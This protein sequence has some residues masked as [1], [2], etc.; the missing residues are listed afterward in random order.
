MVPVRHLKLFGGLSIEDDAG[1][2][3]GRAAQR[4]RLAVLALLATARSGSVSRDRLITYVWPEASAENGRHFLSDSVYRINQ[5]LGGDIILAAGDELRLDGT[6]LPSDVADFEAALLAGDHERAVSVYTGPFLD[7]F[8]LPDS[9]EFE[10]WTEAERDRLQ[11]ACLG[12]LETVA[13]DA[14]RR[15]HLQVAVAYWR[16]VAAFDPY[17]SRIAVQLMEALDAAGDRAAAIQ[18]ARI[19]ET[20]LREE[21]EIEPDPDV[22]ALADAL[23]SGRPISSAQAVGSPHRAVPSGGAGRSR[24]DAA[25][26]ATP[27]S[28][29]PPPHAGQPVRVPRRRTRRALIPLV[30][31][32]ALALAIGG[33]LRLSEFPGDRAADG[34]AP[35]SVAVLPLAHLG[36]DP[37]DEYFSEGMTEELIVTLGRVPG[38]RVASRTSVFAYQDSSLDVREV[39]RRLGVDA[40]IEGSVR[41]SGRTLRISA[42]LVSTA[43]GYTLWSKVYDREID[44]ALAVQEEIAQAMAQTLTGSDAAPAPARGAARSQP[45][46]AYDLYLRARH[47]WHQRTRHGLL[48][49]IEL[50]EQATAVAPG[51]ARAQAGLADA[52]A[53][54]AFYDYVA[55]RT[56]YPRAEAAARRAQALDSSLAGPHATAGYVLTYYHLD[57]PAA[58]AAFERALALDRGN[59][60]AHQWYANLLTVSGR[61][62]DAEREMRAAQEADPLSLI[63]NAALGWSFYLAGRWEEALEQCR[64]TLDLDPDYQLAHLWGGWALESLGRR[65]EAREWIERAVALSQG[66]VLTTLELAR[67]LAPTAPDS[68]RRIV[69]AVEGRS[70]AGEYVPSYEIAKVHLALGDRA[71]ALRWLERTIEERSHSLAFFEVDPHLAALRGDPAFEQMRTALRP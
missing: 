58:E 60:T 53:V 51:Y 27:A 49:S 35:R 10:S 59:S 24:G 65:A 2:V 71:A 52:Y 38:L 43:S 18:H 21:L 62:V 44:D 34:D 63:A 28:P 39:G 68:A 25:T 29:S 19:H 23:R 13:R 70:A 1:P 5:A 55:P 22:R 9:V 11:R 40:V 50:L 15:G 47:A 7:G 20:L 8:H 36:G 31:I 48:R 4:R 12:A 42:Q 66:S 67:L 14:T 69:R 32:V 37:A 56:A 41:K 45:A 64:R 16:R 6:R 26:D 61:F 30:A 17:S 33:T 57:W 3:T 54:A 46:E